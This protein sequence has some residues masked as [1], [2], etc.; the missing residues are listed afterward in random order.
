MF[1][2]RGTRLYAVRLGPYKA[3]FITEEPY[4]AD[5]NRQVHEPPLLFQLE[6]DPGERW[7]IASAHPEVIAEIRELV[8]RHQAEFK[9]GEPQL[10]RRIS[11]R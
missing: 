1:F 9:P 8:A 10:D 3:H 7:N 6:I 4:G 11:E 2:Y 5:T